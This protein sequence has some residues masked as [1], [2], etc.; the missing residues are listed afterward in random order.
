MLDLISVR[1]CLYCFIDGT[2]HEKTTVHNPPARYGLLRKKF[3][4]S[5]GEIETVTKMPGN[6]HVPFCYCC[7][8]PLR[9]VGSNHPIPAQGE[10]WD[11][12]KCPYNKIHQDLIPSL[13]AYVWTHRWDKMIMI[14]RALGTVWRPKK[15]E[16]FRQWLC[17]P[18]GA[19]EVQHHFQFMN[20]FHD[21]C[22]DI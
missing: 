21:T 16:E 15:S 3:I 1:G 6:I 5:R 13:I 18:V 11:H 7:W 17:A 22:D 20:A 9:Q 12:S 8:V 2:S 4:T 10:F 14:S 19:T